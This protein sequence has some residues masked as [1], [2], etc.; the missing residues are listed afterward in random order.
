[1]I[2]QT[3]INQADQNNDESDLHSEEIQEIIYKVPSKILVWGI[4]LI[5]GILAV[6]LVASAYVE[7]PETLKADCKIE[8]DGNIQTVFSST[9]GRIAQVFVKS[10]SQVAKGQEI[11]V[12]QSNVS[13]DAIRM[14]L[15]KFNDVN[16]RSALEQ[17]KLAPY[18]P[19]P[20]SLH[21]GDLDDQYAKLFAL[22]KRKISQ[23]DFLHKAQLFKNNL[24]KLMSRYVYSAPISGSISFSS[25]LEKGVEVDSNQ[26]VFSVQ[27]HSTMRYGYV[28]ITPD[29][30]T[31][32]QLGQQVIVTVPKSMF[33]SG[34]VFTGKLEF[35]TD[36]PNEKGLFMGKATFSAKDLVLLNQV[37]KNAPFDAEIVLSDKSIFQRFIQSL[38]RY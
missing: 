15:Q 17:K 34:L 25:I 27:S 9:S 37:P 29:Y 23:A 2:K 14:L 1:M 18:L 7:Y 31:K 35:I 21:L 22:S 12:I 5:L 4:P 6:M 3:S 11:A 16:K 38:K 24:E 8:G 20:D 36:E 30:I 33:H 26:K 32:V 10:G 13:L 19:L 28:A